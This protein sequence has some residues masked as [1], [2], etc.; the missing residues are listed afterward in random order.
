[1]T[2]EN[3]AWARNGTLRSL[4]HLAVI[5]PFQNRALCGVNIA[6][7]VEIRP[8][9]SLHWCPR[10]MRKARLLGIDAGD[11]GIPNDLVSS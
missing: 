11:V 4:D 8:I 7:M 6:D 5:E 2:A 9:T 3:L 1:M 10:C